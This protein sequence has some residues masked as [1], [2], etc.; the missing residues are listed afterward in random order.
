MADQNVKLASMAYRV[1]DLYMSGVVW[2]Q[3]RGNPGCCASLGRVSAVPDKPLRARVSFAVVSQIPD[4]W[5]TSANLGCIG[6][7]R[8]NPAQLS[9]HFRK[10]Q[11]QKISAGRTHAT[12][13]WLGARGPQVREF[14]TERGGSCASAL[15]V[16]WGCVAEKARAQYGTGAGA[17]AQN[18][19]CGHLLSRIKNTVPYAGCGAFAAEI[20]WGPVS[21][22]IFVKIPPA[23]IVTLFGH[24]RPPADRKKDTT[25]KKDQRI[26]P[27]SLWDKN[28]TRTRLARP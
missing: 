27:T 1:S 21:G 14:W 20:L 3:K 13:I 12:K 7:W 17:W 11:A 25:S 2:F 28:M 16:P 5:G 19:G 24:L 8:R 23:G 6:R 10:P 22:Q 26:Q 15:V 18:D 9:E 4:C